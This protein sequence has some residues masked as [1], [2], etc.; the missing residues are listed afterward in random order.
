MTTPLKAYMAGPW[1]FRPAPDIESFRQRVRDFCDGPLQGAI[2]PIF[3]M[4]PIVNPSRNGTPFTMDFTDPVKIAF[5]CRRH[6][7]RCDVIVADVTPFRGV[8]PDPGTVLEIGFAHGAGK[9]VWLYSG[10]PIPRLRDRLIAEKRASASQD[11]DNLGYF[12]EDFGLPVD[13]MLSPYPYFRSLEE[14]LVDVGEGFGA[15]VAADQ[16]G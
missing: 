4:D 7:V 6:I 9:D 15:P 11:R 8:Q 16:E 5:H 2:T 10:E 12:I 1:V 14:A 13:T 3:P